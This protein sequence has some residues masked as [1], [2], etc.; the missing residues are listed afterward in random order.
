M[1]SSDNIDYRNSHLGK[2]SCYD[3]TIFSS[4]FDAYLDKW[5]GYYLG[6]VLQQLYPISIKRYLDFACGTGRIT[7]RIAP[8]SVESCGV[9]ISESMIG[10]AREKCP[11]TTFI[12]ADT[13]EN[14][15]DIGLFDL[16]TAFRFFGNAQDSLREPAL[17]V[18]NRHLHRGGYLIINNH[19]NPYTL[20][21][22]IHKFTGTGGEKL[23]LPYSKLKKMLH[24]H[25]FEI[26][27]R[28][29]I[30]FWIFRDR[31]VTSK[32]L[33]SD[34]ADKLER[35]FSFSWLAPWAPDALLVIR[36][37]AARP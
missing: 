21:G 15:V 1:S 28:Q 14:N 2:G 12:C 20:S 26:V 6:N 23:T 4:P 34:R 35:I 9:D 8:I 25:G 31:L 37:A 32:I 36:K 11:E 27:M 18:I 10:K 19:R 5:E 24:R 13:T 7:R 33:E 22:F 17:A 30:G 29:P 16:V 3:Q